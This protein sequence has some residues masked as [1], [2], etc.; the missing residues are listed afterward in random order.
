[1]KVDAKVI[2]ITLDTRFLL[3]DQKLADKLSE[4]KSAGTPWVGTFLLK[5][6]K[7]RTDGSQVL[8]T[9]EGGEGEILRGEELF[10]RLHEYGTFAQVNI[11][12]CVI[13][14]ES[15]WFI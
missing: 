13:C 12:Q 2:L 1:M 7:A 15:E 9:A 11:S 10:K 8:S 14:V 3:Q 5:D 4:L 6:Q